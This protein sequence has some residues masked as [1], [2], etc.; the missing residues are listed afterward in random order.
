LEAL[1]KLTAQDLKDIAVVLGSH[2]RK[3]LDSIAALHGKTDAVAER[4]SAVP[5]AERRQRTVML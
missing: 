5:D 4:A 1:P 3:L 2:R